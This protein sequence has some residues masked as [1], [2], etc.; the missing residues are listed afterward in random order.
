MPDQCQ[1]RADTVPKPVPWK[2][3][4]DESSKAYY[5][6]C[7][8]VEMGPEDR[9]IRKLAKQL[10]RGEGASWLKDLSRRYGWVERAA[11]WDDEQ[12]RL[13]MAEHDMGKLVGHFATH[14]VNLGL[15]RLSMDDVDDLTRAEAVK[16]VS[17]GMR[18]ERKVRTLEQPVK[19]TR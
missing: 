19:K 11:A 14:M 2:R 1:T 10:H 12:M 5:A 7:R 13:D 15:T 16:M 6:F 9:S 8:Y 4:P 18:L 17:E 3:Q